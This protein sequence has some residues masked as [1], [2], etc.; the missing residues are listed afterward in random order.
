M[1]VGQIL[2]KI[3]VAALSCF[4]LAGCGNQNEGSSKNSEKKEEIRI[5][6]WGGDSRNQAIQETIEKF[7]EENPNITVKAEFSGFEGYQQKLTTQL[8]GGTAPDVVRV[9]SIWLDEYQNQLIDLTDVKDTV[10]MDNFDKNVLAPLTFQGKILGLPLSTNYRPIYYNKTVL[11]KYGIEAPESWEDIFA[12]REKLPDELY[13]LW[14]AFNPKAAEPQF[15]FSIMAQQTGKP[16]GDDDNKLLYT[17]KDFKKALEFYVELVEKRIIPSKEVI[18][19]S[20]YVDGAPMPPVVNGEWVMAVEFTANTMNLQNSL[21]EKGFELALA[22]FPTMEGQKSSGVWTKPAM[23]YSIPESSKHKEAAAKLIDYLM[24][25][26][27]ANHIQK[28]ENGVPDSKVG[29]EILEEEDLLDPLIKSAVDLGNEMVDPNLSNSYRWNR[30]RLQDTTLDVVNGLDYGKMTV[31]EA[32]EMMYQAF[33]EEES[34]FK[35]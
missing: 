25:S 5:S 32:A 18:D 17:K 19:N 34:S 27:E 9:D 7:E 30:L 23:V 8:S 3:S 21:A 29:M 33:K 28:L 11:D 14:P 26:E 22:G 10:G 20:G 1:R 24:N 16:V 4:V 15:F 6:W 31:D 35:G 13:P 2:A 12:M